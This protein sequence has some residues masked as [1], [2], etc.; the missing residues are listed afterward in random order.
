[1]ITFRF[2]GI[3]V[4]SAGL[5]ACGVSAADPLPGDW[6]DLPYEITSVPAFVSGNT[7]GFTDDVDWSCPVAGPAPDVVYRY[8]AEQTGFLVVDLCGSAYD[9]KMF[10]TDEELNLIG[11]NDDFYSFSCGEYVSLLDDAPIEAGNTYYIFI[12]GYVNCCGDYEAAIYLRGDCDVDL[13]SATVVEGEDEIQPGY[14]D[15]Y[16]HG[17][18]DSGEP[19]LSTLVGDG[20]G[21]AVMAGYS[22]WTAEA[23]GDRDWFHAVSIGETVAV[24]VYSE[25]PLW[26][27][28]TPLADCGDSAGWEPVFVPACESTEF[29]ISVEG[30]GNPL[31]IGL[32]PVGNYRPAG[33]SGWQFSYLMGLEGISADIVAVESRTW[34]GVKGLFR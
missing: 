29:T 8:V 27:I 15:E 18:L 5:L 22:G 3:T 14:V 25:E 4:I 26:F 1:M 34:S 24:S 9:T 6:I 10:V 12:D 21:T 31:W 2:F 19:I 11:C 16:N 33:Y 17:C 32:R 28:G 7:C 13:S 30:P 20:N 23:S